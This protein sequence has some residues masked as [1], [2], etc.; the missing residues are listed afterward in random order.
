MKDLILGSNGWIARAGSVIDGITVGP[1]AKPD[2][3]PETNWTKL[4]SIERFEPNRTVQ[5]VK[6]M[7]P[8]PGVYKTRKV[9]NTGAELTLNFGLQEFTPMMLAELLLGGTQPV[10]GVFEPN[11]RGIDLEAWL[12]L[13]AYDQDNIRIIT[14]DVYVALSIA[15]YQFQNGIEPY[16][17]VAEVLY[18]SLNSGLIENLTE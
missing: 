5:R 16:T 13:Q 3:S 11:G 1:E 14:L 18:S 9:I 4:P 8:N 17:L 10:A 15:S 2:T 7:S 12:K 6:R